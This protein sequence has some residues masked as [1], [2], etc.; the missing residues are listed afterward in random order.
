MIDLPTVSEI[1]QE[2]FWKL[3]ACSMLLVVIF[4]LSWYKK[5]SLEKEIGIAFIRGFCQLMVLSLVL[6]FLFEQ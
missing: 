2:G 1:A 6:S 5:L 3:A 4:A